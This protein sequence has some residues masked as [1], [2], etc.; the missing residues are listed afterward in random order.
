MFKIEFNVTKKLGTIDNE[1]M[2]VSEAVWSTYP[3]Y[4]ENITI[5]FGNYLI[6]LDKKGD[7]SVIYNDVVSMLKKLN[8]NTEFEISFL[9]SGFTAYWDFVKQ[10]N[11]IIITPKWISAGLEDRETSLFIENVKEA[12]FPKTVNIEIFISEWHKFLKSI[13][14][15]LLKVGYTEDLE[16]FEYLKNLK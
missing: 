9:S 11:S 8:K 14:D 4:T 5:T 16:N 3:N 2:S 6:H 10:E 15:D 7:M 13:K 1:D 12:N